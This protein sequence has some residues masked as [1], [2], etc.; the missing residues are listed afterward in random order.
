MV[1][2][3]IALVL[4]LLTAEV[5]PET[6]EVR[7]RGLVELA[8]F[9]CRDIRRSSL[10]RR[11]CYDAA[12]SHLIVSIRND[13]DQYCDLP[14]TTFEALM[15]APSMGQFFHRNIKAG[16]FGCHANEKPKG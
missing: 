5:G 13:Y 12:Q 16:P 4:Q 7:D 10:I 6:V 15:A 3:A 2:A 11:V 1:K 9:E 8:P 14:P